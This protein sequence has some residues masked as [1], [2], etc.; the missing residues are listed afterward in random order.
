MNSREGSG[1][2]GI[3]IIIYFHVLVMILIKEKLIWQ[4]IIIII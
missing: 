3:I 2:S 4:I 1:W